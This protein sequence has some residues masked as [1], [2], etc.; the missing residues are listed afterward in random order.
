[1]TAKTT[2][3]CRNISRRS[4]A[5]PQLLNNTAQLETQLKQ[6]I[7]QLANKLEALK[8]V[9]ANIDFA[10]VRTYAEMIH[11]RQ[12]LFKEIKAGRSKIR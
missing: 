10:L 8:G 5:L 12:Q 3:R 11:S 1:M 4:L 6:E 9:S 2:T 7:R